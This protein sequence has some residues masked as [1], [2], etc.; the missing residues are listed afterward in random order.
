MSFYVLIILYA[1][2]EL[3]G[4]EAKALHTLG[5]SPI[6]SRCSPLVSSSL[7]PPSLRFFFFLSRYTAQAGLKLVLL[8]HS[9]ECWVYRPVPPCQLVP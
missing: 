8:P 4:D 1:C 6:T 5:E 9:P 2:V 7:L 3:A